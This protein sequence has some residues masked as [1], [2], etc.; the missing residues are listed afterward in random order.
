[1]HYEPG[2]ILGPGGYRGKLTMTLPL[3]AHGLL[4]IGHRGEGEGVRH[5][6]GR[7]HDT[8]MYRI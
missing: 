4:V 2:T 8:G 5:T 7:Y 3:G 6:Y 1:M